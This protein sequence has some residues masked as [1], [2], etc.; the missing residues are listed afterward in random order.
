M[1]ALKR[2]I[3]VCVVKSFRIDWGD[4]GIAALV[5][6]MAHIALFVLYRR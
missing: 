4:V 3:S 6:G 2:K 1:G 5:V